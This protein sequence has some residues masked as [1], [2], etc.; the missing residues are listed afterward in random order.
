MLNMLIITYLGYSTIDFRGFTTSSLEQTT[1]VRLT[2][3]VAIPCHHDPSS[4]P[5]PMIDWLKDG[6]PI[7]FDNHKYV[8]LPD[9]KLAIYRLK[10]SDITNGNK[11]VKYQC[12][13]TNANV[14]EN[15]LSPTKHTLNTGNKII[16]AHIH[17]GE[18]ESCFFLCSIKKKTI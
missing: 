7:H 16:H 15:V 11:S 8:L 12:M 14:T 4:L 10:D 18:V 17:T 1:S 13:V 6:Q 5:P 3:L 2:E 9:G